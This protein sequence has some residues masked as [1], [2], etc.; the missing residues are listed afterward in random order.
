M[1]YFQHGLIYTDDVL[2]R[3]DGFLESL[4]DAVHVWHELEVVILDRKCA[5]SKALNRKSMGQYLTWRIRRELA[6]SKNASTRLCRFTVHVKCQ[7]AP[8]LRIA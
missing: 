5:F 6:S 8:R 7:L 4:A 1:T 3:S 2:Q